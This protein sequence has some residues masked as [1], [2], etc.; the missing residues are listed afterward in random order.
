MEDF[1]KHKFPTTEA[2]PPAVGTYEA[3]RISYQSSEQA[4]RAAFSEIQ[5]LREKLR[6]A[7]ERLKVAEEALNKAADVFHDYA[8]LHAA[9]EQTPE[10]TAKVERNLGYSKMCDEALAKIRSD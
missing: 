8:E 1:F 10:N 2:T 7:G 3:W 5:T 4:A 9:K 6:E